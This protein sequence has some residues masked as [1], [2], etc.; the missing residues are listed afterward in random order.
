MIQKDELEDDLLAK[1]KI[2]LELEYM[3]ALKTDELD[4]AKDTLFTYED[5]RDE[6]KR[7]DEVISR[8]IYNLMKKSEAITEKYRQILRIKDELES[9]LKDTDDIMAQL[10]QENQ[11]LTTEVSQLERIE[12]EIE[13]QVALNNKLNEKFCY[14]ENKFLQRQLLMEE[15]QT[16]GN[17]REGDSGE[18]DDEIIEVNIE[19]DQNFNIKTSSPSKGT[20]DILACPQLHLDENF[21]IKIELE[22][23]G[24]GNNN[25][26]VGSREYAQEYRDSM[27][28]SNQSSTK[29]TSKFKSTDNFNNLKQQTANPEMSSEEDLVKI[30]FGRNEM[31]MNSKSQEILQLYYP[32]SSLGETGYNHGPGGGGNVEGEIEMQHHYYSNSNKNLMGLIKENHSSGNLRAGN[33]GAGHLDGSSGK[34]GSSRNH[35]KHGS[36]GKGG[37]NGLY[38]RRDNSHSFGSTAKFCPT[39]NSRDMSLNEVVRDLV[40]ENSAIIDRL[41]MD[42]LGLAHAI[43]D[44]TKKQEYA[45]LSKSPKITITGQN[46]ASGMVDAQIR[47]NHQGEII[48]PNYSNYLA[49]YEYEI[50]T[51]SPGSYQPHPAPDSRQNLMAD[52][53]ENLLYNPQPN[54][55]KAQTSNQQEYNHQV[56][57]SYNPNP[58]SSPNNYN[59]YGSFNADESD[60]SLEYEITNAD[61]ININEGSGAEN[62]SRNYYSG[63]SRSQSSEKSGGMHFAK[64][65]SES[66]VEGVAKLEAEISPYKNDRH[67]ENNL[68][69]PTKKYS[70]SKHVS[71]DSANIPL[72]TL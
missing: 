35:G 7:K 56:Y 20:S 65:P 51:A 21:K 72:K 12:I 69:S 9:E 2:L 58:T 66:R 32:R 25:L 15:G 36:N 54:R 44:E 38:K 43:Q 19:D 71:K 49:N 29:M 39:D 60:P 18:N 28:T 33:A 50:N 5:N 40:Q 34:R 46:Q 14:F 8:N 47:I 45:I 26:R 68:A 27:M 4:Q 1:E 64:K 16:G 6:L 70:Y 48:D 62:N 23:F 3:E 59:S 37:K 22:D 41:E 67:Q 42:T 61:N 10:R 31:T 24:N 17:E 57:E 11:A 63:N 13:E 52:E 55:N 53:M 30:N